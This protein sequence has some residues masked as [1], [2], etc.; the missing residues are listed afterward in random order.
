ME[1]RVVHDELGR[2]YVIPAHILSD[3]QTA[4]PIDTSKSN[5]HVLSRESE[6]GSA[7]LRAAATTLGGYSVPIV[8]AAAKQNTAPA[9]VI[10]AVLGDAPVT[11]QFGLLSEVFR[12]HA[13]SDGVDSAI[14]AALAE[15]LLDKQQVTLRLGELAE[16]VRAL[17]Q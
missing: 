9:R 16:L 11:V 3:F 15:P 5:G 4:K 12:R 14:V 6:N 1:M 10:E 7:G 8:N 17:K 2:S 13:A